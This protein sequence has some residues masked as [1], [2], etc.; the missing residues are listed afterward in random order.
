MRDHHDAEAGIAQLPGK[1]DSGIAARAG[2]DDVPVI[3]AGQFFHDLKAG[4][5]VILAGLIEIVHLPYHSMH[6]PLCERH[7]VGAGT[8]TMQRV[9]PY[10][11][12]FQG[13]G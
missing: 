11:P 8:T 13:N 5:R 9:E 12:R 6:L 7:A 10:A 1:H 3:L 2:H 4:S